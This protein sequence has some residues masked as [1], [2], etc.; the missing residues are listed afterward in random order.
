MFYAAQQIGDQKLLRK[1]HQH[2]L[3][4]RRYL[5]RGDGSTSHEGIFDLETGEFLRQSTHQGWRG[6]SA[7]ARGQTW[8][9]YGFGTVYDMTGDPRYLQ[10]ARLC[11]DFYIEQTSFDDDAPYGPGVPPNDWDE[12]EGRFATALRIG[13]QGVDA[14]LNQRKAG[15]QVTLSSKRRLSARQVAQ[16]RGQLRRML[17]LDE[18]LAPFWRLCSGTPRPVSSSEQTV[19]TSPLRIFT[20]RRPLCPARPTSSWGP[21]STAATR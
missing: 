21:R 10:A 18:D 13:R 6:D 17:R 5:V 7:W 8:A 4:T 1:A 3:T 11:A 16:A 14:D 19:L 12:N 2:C 15:L 20:R 9:L